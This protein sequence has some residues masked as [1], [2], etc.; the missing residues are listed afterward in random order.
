[1]IRIGAQLVR[2]NSGY[3]G[4]LVGVWHEKVLIQP[5]YDKIKE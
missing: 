3:K 1:M 2:V 5:F 4:V